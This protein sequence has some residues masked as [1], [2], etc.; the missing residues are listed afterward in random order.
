MSTSTSPIRAANE[1]PKVARV[2]VPIGA[3]IRG[4]LVLR[5][6]RFFAD[7]QTDDG[8]NL[9]VHCPNP[10]SMLGCAIPGSVVRCST[11]TPWG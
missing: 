5:Y 1:G 7:I 3:D 6:K 4:R 8:E 11:M 2:S 10:G 9:T